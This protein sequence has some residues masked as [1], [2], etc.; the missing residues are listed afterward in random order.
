M[1]GHGGRREIMRKLGCTSRVQ[2]ARWAWDE[3]G[4]EESSA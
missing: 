3:L 2:V 4:P 1:L